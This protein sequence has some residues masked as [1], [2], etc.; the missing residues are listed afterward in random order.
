MLELYE[1]GTTTEQLN[2]VFSDVKTWLPSLID[3]VIEKQ[4]SESFIAPKGHYPAESQK[5]WGWM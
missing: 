4:S 2:R 1:P 5:R 3:V